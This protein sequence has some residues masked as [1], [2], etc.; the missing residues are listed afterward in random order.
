MRLEDL[1]R[2]GDEVAQVVALPMYIHMYI[3]IYI[4][5]Y[6]YVHIYIYIHT[7][8]YVY[9]YIYIERERE[10]K[11][12]MCIYSGTRQKLSPW[13]LDSQVPVDT[14]DSRSKVHVEEAPGQE[15]VG[16]PFVGGS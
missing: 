15:F 4:Y 11:R 3:Y 16:L 7:H 8:Y 13:P 14:P 12:E 2:L 5:A 10:R 9:I 1:E 6:A